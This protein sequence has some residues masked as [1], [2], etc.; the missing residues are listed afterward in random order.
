M[1]QMKNFTAY[2]YKEI[3]VHNDKA[4]LYLDTGRELSPAGKR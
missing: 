3:T 1:E 4:S 2:E